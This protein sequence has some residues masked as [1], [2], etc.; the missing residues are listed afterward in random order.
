MNKKDRI[1]LLFVLILTMYFI[2]TMYILFKDNEID[3][4][5][6]GDIKKAQETNQYL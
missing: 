1:V 5:E 4:L 6:G 3:H 2:A